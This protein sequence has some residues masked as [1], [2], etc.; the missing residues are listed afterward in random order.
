MAFNLIHSAAFKTCPLGRGKKT[1]P[2]VSILSKLRP[3]GWSC[4]VLIQPYFVVEG[5]NKRER[6][7]YFP[8]VYRLSIDNLLKEAHEIRNLGIKSVLLFGFSQKRDKEASA[9]YDKEG[10]VQ[11]AIRA[12]KQKIEDITVITDVCLCG[13]TTDGHCRIL[14]SKLKF[15]DQ[16]TLEALAKIALSHAEAGADLVAPSAMMDG[17]VRAI[18]KVLGKNGFKKVKILAYSAKY[19]SNFYGPF[20]EA[21]ESAPRFGDRRGYQLGYRDADV[22]LKKIEQD[23]KEG[24]SLVMVKPALA[25]LDVIWRAKQRFPKVPLVAYSSSGEYALLKTGAQKGILFEQAAVLEVLTAIKRAG[26]DLIITYYAKEAAKW[27]R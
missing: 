24:A 3:L 11:R 27:L 2:S 6:I 26:A 13:Y 4:E 14:K 18:R 15:D 12:I 25:Y 17:Q 5:R 1:P 21:L 16:R 19:A 7:K 10:I 20:R 23:I 8:Q 22:A 9:A